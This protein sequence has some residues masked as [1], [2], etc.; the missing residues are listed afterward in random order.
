MNQLSFYQIH[1]ERLESYLAKES[2]DVYVKL[3]KSKFVKIADRSNVDGIE[4]I[5]EYLKKGIRIFY[6]SEVDFK[7]YH[8][9]L[10]NEFDASINAINES[11]L[12]DDEVLDRSLNSIEDI[13]DLLINFG[14]TESTVARVDLVAN[15]TLKS[16][17]KIATF[18][19]LLE[20]L[21]SRDGFLKEQPYLCT[22]IVT[23]IASQM[24]WCNLP[25][26][27]KIIT[28][29]MFQNI[30]L[31]TESQA[32]ILNRDELENSGLEEFEKE[33]ILNHCF[34]SS[35]LASEDSEVFGDE[36]RKLIRYHHAL[37]EGRGFP[38]E[39]ESR[40]LSPLEAIF[41]L[42]VQL[43]S[44]ILIESQSDPYI[45]VQQLNELCGEGPFQKMYPLF[46]EAFYLA[47][48]KK[49]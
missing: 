10:E 40:T 21:N 36:V 28:A 29:S 49:D 20:L 6:L 4:I 8:S 32:K 44:K 22:Y 3:S 46:L 27:K 43:S 31:E 35:E 14:V 11:E 30:S 34:L 1:H 26:I 5:Q 24:E 23:T 9:F 45:C 47:Y 17:E 19:A 38:E 42:S 18:E 13:K 48:P 16:F 2:V 39:S 7:N 33:L 12:F 41:N 25:L 37:P 15:Q